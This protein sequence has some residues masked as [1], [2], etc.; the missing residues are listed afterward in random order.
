[1]QLDAEDDASA[2][3]KPPVEESLQAKPPGNTAIDRA[4]AGLDDDSD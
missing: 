2:F 3:Y 4:R 1:M